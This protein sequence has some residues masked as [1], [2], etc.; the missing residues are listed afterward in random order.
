[1]ERNSTEGDSKL[2]KCTAYWQPT[3]AQEARNRQK[4]K[5][6]LSP[7]PTSFK[8]ECFYS[9]GVWKLDADENDSVHT[10]LSRVNG[11]SSFDLTSPLISV[12][13]S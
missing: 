7:E 3:T 1:M 8:S 2:L 4:Y 6:K 5:V 10:R 11:R 13:D 9:I 12:R